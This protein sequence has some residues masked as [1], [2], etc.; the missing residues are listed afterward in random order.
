M[1][2]IEK[3]VVPL[4][5]KRW[6]K[7]LRNMRW[8]IFSVY[9]RLN[10]LVLLPN[11]LTM[12][13]LSIQHNLVSLPTTAVATAVSVN[14]IVAVLIRQELVINL[15]FALFG[16]CPRSM[17]LWFRRLAAKIYHL[18]GVHSGAGVAATVWFGV[19][20][21]VLAREWQ[22]NTRIGRSPG[23]F[24][25]T[26]TLDCLL[27]SIIVLAHPRLRARYHNTF[28][29]VHRFAG[30]MAVII[31]WIHM[32]VLADAERRTLSPTPTLAKVT[33]QSLSF[34]CLL[35]VSISLIIPW[36]R[37]RKVS[38]HPQ[39]L[40]DHAIRLY[41]THE[42]LPLCAAPRIS[43][44]PLKEW[45]AFAGIPQENGSGFSLLVSNAGDWTSRL[46][47]S[48]PTSIWVRGIPA[49]GVL[50][51]AP[52]FNRLVLVATGSGIGPILSLLFARDLQCR[53]LWSAPD[54][55]S[56][57]KKAIIDQVLLGDP[58]AVIIN[59]SVAG[60]P[61]LVQEAYNL[62]VASNAE[63]VFIISNAKV[64]RK[65]VY[66]LECRGIPTFAPIFDS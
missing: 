11:I 43:D 65:V 66:G 8:S 37:L 23:I 18:G 22:E 19:F 57:Y 34:W 49:R 53:I 52:I 64:T 24:V 16:K 59:T 58:N 41:F 48:P 2:D 6:N 5:P 14:I 55:E 30:W 13:A 50:H 45:H 9:R 3:S 35:I 63:V 38:V 33:F 39:P 32:L 61:D 17:P 60:R 12:I 21:A 40:S 42:N 10:L 29:M 47:R 25:V 20:N 62:Y 54:P 46:I 4:P 56:T 51:V 15:L 7:V 1:S 31:F 44:K 26:G 28:E 27:L 36:L